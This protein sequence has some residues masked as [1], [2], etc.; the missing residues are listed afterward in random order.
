MGF[1]GMAGVLALGGCARQRPSDFGAAAETM[2]DDESEVSLPSQFADDLPAAEDAAAEDVPEGPQSAV[3][4]GSF[5]LANG[6]VTLNNGIA[7]PTNGLGTYS[8]QGQTCIDSV[9]SALSCGVRLVDTAHIYGNESEV[10]QAIRESE[11]PREDSLRHHQ[12]LPKSVL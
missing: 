4:P 2:G 5:D 7:M 11:V 9:K 1:A 12:A 6:V 8:L 3:V 10:G